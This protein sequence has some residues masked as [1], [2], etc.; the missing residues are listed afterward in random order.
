MD[1][2]TSTKA[3]DEVNEYLKDQPREFELSIPVIEWNNVSIRTEFVVDETIDGKQVRE[4]KESYER[5]ECIARTNHV[6]LKGDGD[7]HKMHVR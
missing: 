3:L 7:F 1:R 5:T 2:M 4:K 6:R